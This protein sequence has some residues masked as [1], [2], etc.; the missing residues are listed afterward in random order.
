MFQCVEVCNALPHVWKQ[1]KWRNY[2]INHG[3]SYIAMP[4]NLSKLMLH[5]Y[6]NKIVNG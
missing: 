5:I 3:H 2:I 6:L 4:D 1:P